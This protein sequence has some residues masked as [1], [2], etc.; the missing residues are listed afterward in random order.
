MSRQVKSTVTSPT[1]S[2]AATK[3]PPPSAPG[4]PDQFL[5][6]LKAR[7]EQ[8]MGRHA[9]IAWAKVQTRLEADADTLRALE[10]MERTGGE[11]DVVWHDKATD[12]YVFV[13]CSSETPKGR[14]S[15]CYDPQALASRKEN[16]PKGSALGMAADMGIEILSEDEYRKLQALGEFDARSSSWVQTPPDV[17]QR[18]GA[19]FCDR[20]YGHVF[21]YHN[22]AE[23][24][25]A[26]RGFRGSL[27]V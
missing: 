8:N 5:A 15:L 19:L 14:T 20:R 2:R 12:E 25:Y 26:L 3:A 23:S 24:Y 9:G 10:A 17:R 22:G 6:S 27:R 16:K 1:K 13:D 11:P 18:G 7:F 4:R 21:V